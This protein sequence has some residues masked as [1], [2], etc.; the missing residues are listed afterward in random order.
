MSKKK[1]IPILLLMFLSTGLLLADSDHSTQRRGAYLGLDFFMPPEWNYNGYFILK[2]RER[3][4]LTD[5]QIQKIKK[6]IIEYKEFSIRNSAEVKIKELRLA[7]SLKQENIDREELD[8]QI[9]SLS[10]HKVDQVIK[11]LNY[12]LDLSEVL[13][14]EQQEDFKNLYLE[15]Y[16]S[17]HPYP[18]KKENNFS[19][20]EMREYLY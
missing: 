11:Y 10:K 20:P 8:Q 12:L 9:R 2:F 3:L 5:Q 14:P 18:R 6:L 17:K 7:Y 1:L 16:K 13:T 4:T 19:I 15:F